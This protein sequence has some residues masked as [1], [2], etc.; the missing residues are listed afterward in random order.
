[1]ADDVKRCRDFI[2]ALVHR[3]ISGDLAIVTIGLRRRKCLNESIHNFFMPLL[4]APLT[5][6]KAN[7]QVGNRFHQSV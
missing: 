3:G 5:V 6:R 4:R 2:P 1:M 7:C